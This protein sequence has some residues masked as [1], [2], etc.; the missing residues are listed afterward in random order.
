MLIEHHWVSLLATGNVEALRN[1]LAMLDPAD[2]EANATFAA[3]AA[4]ASLQAGNIA[5]ALR[6]IAA[7]QPQA[8]DSGIP[9][10]A[11]DFVVATTQLW[12][13]DASGARTSLSAVLGSPEVDVSIT[14][15]AQAHLVGAELWAG[16]L[17]HVLATCK[18]LLDVTP[19]DHVTLRA[20]LHGYLAVALIEKL[21]FAGAHQLAESAM[22]EVGSNKNACGPEVALLLAALGLAQRRVGETEAAL[23]TLT[24]AATAARGAGSL[25]AAYA[26]IALAG[27]LRDRGE[28]EKARELTAEA[29]RHRGACPDDGPIIEKAWQRDTKRA[30]RQRFES[31]GLA[32]PFTARELALLQ[33]LPTEMTQRELGERL[34]VSFNTVKSYN[35]SIYRKLGVSSRSEAVQ[36]AHDLGLLD[37]TSP[38]EQAPTEADPPAPKDKPES[39]NAACLLYT[40]PSPRD[41]TL[42]RMPSS[43]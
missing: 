10:R 32:E 9:R 41:A 40:S 6:Y 24:R 11:L 3:A 31:S 13:G 37:A 34:I 18:R 43:A 27:A 23:S 33:L 26:T 30:R 16:S 12:R 14:M 36:V 15:S 5:A 17:D 38:P 7:G 35:R 42:S 39:H 2:I 25:K 20:E 21:D 28:I 4:A 19:A 22:A 8:P 29:R 1:A